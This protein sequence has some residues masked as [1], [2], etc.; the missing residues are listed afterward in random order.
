MKFYN[1]LYILPAFMLMA[2]DHIKFRKDYEREVEEK[3]EKKSG[4]QQ[5]PLCY[6]LNKPQVFK[7]PKELNEISGITFL[8]GNA[9]V[10]F[11]EEDENGKLFR[12]ALS[13][14]N[15]SIT[16]WGKSGDYEDI[17]ICNGYI[18]MLRSN[19]SL[20]SFS[21]K[22]I[23]G[24]EVKKVNKFEDILPHGEYESLYADNN[25]NQLFALCKHCNEKLSVTNSG[26]IFSVSDKGEITTAGTKMHF[27]P[28]E[29]AKNETTGEWFIVSSI[30]KLLVITDS[31]WRVKGAYNLDKS[32]YNQPEGIAF[33][34]DNNLY[35][36]NEKGSTGSATIL[37]I[38]CK[39]T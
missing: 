22:D 16:K 3:A 2:C 27:Q 19:G 7:M 35:I 1:C 11:A 34:K 20:F 13:S 24:G 29:F 12:F 5:T 36:S 14:K 8:N 10:V 15:I 4:V 38:T 26:Y 9:D 21:M 33:D 23:D 18:I 6:D 17:Q 37:K 30:N 39:K 25:S 31:N 28:S 32:L